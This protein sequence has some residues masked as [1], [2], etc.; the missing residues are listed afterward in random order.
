MFGPLVDAQEWPEG[1]DVAVIEGAV[2]SQDDLKLAQT[3]RAAQQGRG[4]PRRLRGD[5]QRALDAQRHPHPASSSSAIYVEGATAK[6]GVPTDGVPAPAQAGGAAA[7]GGQGRRPRPGLPAEAERHPA[8]AERAARGP[9]ARPRL[10]AAVRVGRAWRPGEQ[11]RRRARHGPRDP[12]GEVPAADAPA[13]QPAE[14]RRPAMNTV[15]IHHVSR[16]EGHAKITIKLD[17]AGA[18][19][20]HPVPRHPGPRLREVH[21][22]PALLRDA[23]DHRPH[24]RHLP[25]EPPARVVE[26]VRRDHGRAHPGDGGRSSASC[27]TARSSCSRTRSRSS[28]SRRP[29]CCWAWT[30]TLRRATSRACSRSTPTPC[31]TGSP[32]ASSASR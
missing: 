10:Q 22:G 29:T 11:R 26:G 30:T 13:A 24:L 25:G 3:A 16:I 20:R 32:C 8:C 9:Q 2:S 18:G 15:T 21:R 23:V 17:D 7:R 1:V 6:P 28:T 27:S 19:G 4:R 14:A 31:A 12:V 5:E